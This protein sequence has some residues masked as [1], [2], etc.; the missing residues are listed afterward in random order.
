MYWEGSK[1]ELEPVIFAYDKDKKEYDSTY[2]DD[3][4]EIDTTKLKKEDWKKDPDEGM[5]DIFGSI[6]YS[7]KIPKDAI[8]LI[9]EGTGEDN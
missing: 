5:Y 8:K 9:Y 4:Y 7:K 2:D 3:I 6:V 1:K